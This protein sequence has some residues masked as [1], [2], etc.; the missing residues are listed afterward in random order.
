MTKREKYLALNIELDNVEKAVYD[1]RNLRISKIV[2]ANVLTNIGTALAKIGVDSGTV[3]QFLSKATSGAISPTTFSSTLSNGM[4]SIPGLSS[5]GKV[6]LGFGTWEEVYNMLSDVAQ[7]ARLIAELAPMIIYTIGSLITMDTLS[8]EEA[9]KK[10]QDPLYD[11]EQT[12]ATD[13][14]AHAQMGGFTGGGFGNIPMNTDPTKVDI[15]S[16]NNNMIRTAVNEV[17]LS[18]E[19]ASKMPDSVNGI[20]KRFMAIANDPNTGG[21][22][23][24][25]T[26]AKLQEYYNQVNAQYGSILK[27]LPKVNL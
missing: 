20:L 26:A 7:S 5:A 9:T 6:S 2:T 15:T 21:A 18:G 27:K 1:K 13:A 4:T 17:E 22:N 23:D 8:P 16:S 11:S 10:V 19:D 14:Q 12:A 24:P 25:R 3:T